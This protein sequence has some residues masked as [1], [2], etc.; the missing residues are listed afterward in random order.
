LLG[1]GNVIADNGVTDNRIL[2][3]QSAALSGPASALGT[4]MRDGA[5]TYFDAVNASGGV[6]GRQ[7]V[8]NTLDDGCDPERAGLKTATL[9]DKDR[10]FA[11]FGYVGTPTLNAVQSWVEK[12]GV[13]FFAPMTSAESFRTPFNRN[14][15]NIRDGYMAERERSSSSSTPWASRRW[16]CCYGRHTAGVNKLLRFTST[17]CW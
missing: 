2:L 5:L 12:G 10:M 9:V 3:G 15:F 17:P 16:R 7:I 4:T 14:V 11:L 6:G 13:P 8:L 1:T